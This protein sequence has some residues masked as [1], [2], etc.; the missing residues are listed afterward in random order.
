MF[1]SE[2]EASQVVGKCGG[3]QYRKK[4]GGMHKDRRYE[5]ERNSVRYWI[6]IPLGK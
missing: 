2:L 5:S 6:K 3:Q 4:V 1:W